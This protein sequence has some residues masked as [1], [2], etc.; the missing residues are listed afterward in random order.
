[1]QGCVP[2]NGWSF[3]LTHG[4]R[5]LPTCIPDAEPVLVSHMEK[6]YLIPGFNSPILEV[7]IVL[8]GLFKNVG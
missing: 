5:I 7:D 8:S 2:P 6:T 3:E 4:L 1:M